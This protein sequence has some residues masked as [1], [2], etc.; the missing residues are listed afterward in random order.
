MNLHRLGGGSGKLELSPVSPT[1]AGM[2]MRWTLD[3][4]CNNDVMMMT[5]YSINP[6]CS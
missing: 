3:R 6:I 1:Q 2:E 4:T 5:F